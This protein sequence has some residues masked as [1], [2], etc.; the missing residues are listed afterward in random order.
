MQSYYIKFRNPPF[1]TKKRTILRFLEEYLSF[2]G[3]EEGMG[4]MSRTGMMVAMI[5]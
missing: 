2:L 1:C 3:V 4:M 5:A